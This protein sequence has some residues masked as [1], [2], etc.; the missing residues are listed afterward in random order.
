MK[1]DKVLDFSDS[2]MFAMSI[3]NIIGLYLLAGILKAD[4]AHYWQ[5]YKAGHFEIKAGDD[6]APHPH[7]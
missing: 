3:F 6:P 1:L 7:L 5:R 4:L 2:M